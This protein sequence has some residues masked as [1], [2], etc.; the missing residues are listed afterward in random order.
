[1]TYATDAEVTCPKCGGKMWD[2]RATKTNP[3]APDFKCRDRSCDGVVWP[4]KGAKNG[5]GNRVAE[6]T[7]PES[8]YPKHA[9]QPHPTG[10][11]AVS[12]SLQEKLSLY[13]E[14]FAHAATIAKLNAITDQQAIAAMAATIFIQ[15]VR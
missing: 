3:K 11:R 13:D 10:A 7:Q 14:C 12:T 4:P 9:V 5:N 6:H 1:M 15:A 8:D 2:N